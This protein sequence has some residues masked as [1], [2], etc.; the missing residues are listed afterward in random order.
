VIHLRL[1]PSPGPARWTAG[2]SAP[3]PAAASVGARAVVS[4]ASSRACA[5]ASS[6]PTKR[7]AWPCGQAG[8]RAAGGPVTL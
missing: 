1:T 2:E 7:P 8:L 4:T 3:L 6:P 5:Y